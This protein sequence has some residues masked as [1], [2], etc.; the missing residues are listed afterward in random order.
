[1]H[2]LWFQLGQLAAWGGGQGC[3]GRGACCHGGRH[4]R[5]TVC[6]HLELSGH[7]R[8]LTKGEGVCVMKEPRP[9]PQGST[10]KEVYREQ[11]EDARVEWG[12]WTLPNLR[13]APFPR[14]HVPSQGSTCMS[15]DVPWGS[16]FSVPSSLAEDPT[17]CCCFCLQGSKIVN[18]GSVIL[19]QSPG[20]PGSSCQGDGGSEGSAGRPFL[21]VR[22]PIVKAQE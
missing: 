19:T 7:G 9:C 11:L 6:W 16:S 1:M 10:R 21:Q 18:S 12:S 20:L 4:G 17:C 3:Q 8:G 22:I 2:R 15:Q 13:E 14:S 5:G